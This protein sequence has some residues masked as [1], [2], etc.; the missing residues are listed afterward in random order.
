MRIEQWLHTIPLRLRS[1]FH[2]NRMGAE[3]DEELRDHI[4][5]QTEQN[6]A[7]G[8][9]PE[10][11]RLAAERA[12]G[13]PSTL[14]DQ[15]HDILRSA[16]DDEDGIE[17]LPVT[18]GPIVPAREQLGELLLEQGNLT[19]ASRAFETALANAPGRRGALLG[20]RQVGHF[21]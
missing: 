17:K 15:T 9:A 10:Q 12:F 20:A 16:A 6:L 1:L 11:A 3:L 7:R 14:R 19:E 18:P 4:D 21:H 2:R 8:M 5:R 13:N